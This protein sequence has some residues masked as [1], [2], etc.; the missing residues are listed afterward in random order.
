MSPSYRSFTWALIAQ[1]LAVA[2]PAFA[3]GSKPPMPA[4]AAP[5][6]PQDLGT[7][8]SGGLRFSAQALPDEA[9]AIEVR[10][11]RKIDPADP[12][13]G[14][15]TPLADG[16]VTVSI[17]G[18]RGAVASEESRAEGEAGAYG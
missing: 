15:W 13:L 5:A 11:D 17:R 1:S 9:L 10:I 3:H 12:V 2:A 6:A 16:K 14:G 4:P 7:R 18:V 8:E